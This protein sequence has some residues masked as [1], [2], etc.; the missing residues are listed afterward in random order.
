VA[1]VITVIA[2]VIIVVAVVTVV[3]TIN[4]LL[5]L[6]WCLLCLLFGTVDCILLLVVVLE[7]HHR[8]LPLFSLF[9]RIKGD[10]VLGVIS[11]SLYGI[12]GTTVKRLWRPFQKAH[13]GSVA[14]A[15]FIPEAH[16]LIFERRFR[17]HSG[18]GQSLPIATVLLSSNG[19]ADVSNA[20][21]Y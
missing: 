16:Y 10:G 18:D 15:T 14:S 5:L 7:S 12:T 6:R 9:D 11:A 8:R 2:M 13:E 3:I 20:R 17:F 4:R 1:F 21:C 19:R